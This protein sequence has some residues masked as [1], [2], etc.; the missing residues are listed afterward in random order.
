VISDKPMT[1]EPWIRERATVID[2][3]ATDVTPTG[4][5]LRDVPSDDAVFCQ[6]LDRDDGKPLGVIVRFNEDAPTYAWVG[7][8]GLR[9]DGSGARYFNA[10]RL[11]ACST[12][13]AAGDAVERALREVGS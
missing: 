10:R 11:G 3:E 9:R 2:G 8:S 7:I 13:Q 12:D 6:T 4:N 1:E 5:D